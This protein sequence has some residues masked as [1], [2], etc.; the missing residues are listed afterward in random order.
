[1]NVARRMFLVRMAEKI[2]ANKTFAEKI[3]TKNKS[4]LRTEDAK[5]KE[6]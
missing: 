1:M 5:K 3:G 2:D 4:K 6:E